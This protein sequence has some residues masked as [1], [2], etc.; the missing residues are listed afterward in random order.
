MTDIHEFNS[1]PV[2]YVPDTS[3]IISGELRKFLIEKKIEAGSKIIIHASLLAELEYQAN[4]GRKSGLA[5]LNEIRRLR[6][7]C[8]EYDI[9]FEYAGR[10][11][12]ASEIKL[13]R[14]GEIDALIRDFAW[15]ATGILITSDKIQHLSTEA[16]GGE[17]IYLQ[18]SKSNLEKTLG[19]E[20]YFDSE[21]LSVHLKQGAKTYVKRGKPGYVT[22]EAYSDEISSK[23]DLKEYAD[24]IIQKAQLFE[25]AFIEIDR[26]GSTIVQYA[27]MRI[28]I[29]RPPF[30]DGWEITAV[31]PLVNLTI[32]DYSLSS[33]L[34]DRLIRRAEGILI[35]GSPGEG[36]TTFARAL[37]LFYEG[38]SQV[39]KTIESPRD[40]DLKTEITQYS[41]NFGKRT[42]IHD[43][44]LLSRP[45]YTIFDE[46][47]DTEDFKL[48]TDLRLAG[49]GL[50]G[51]IHSSTAIDA[52]QR[53]IGRLELGVIPS[54]LDTIIYIKAGM[55]SQV[56]EV[57]MTVK[58]PSGLTESDL[59]RPVVEV[60]DFET[61]ELVYELY[62]F[63]EQT[64]VIPL[65]DIANKIE[66]IDFSTLQEITEA[67]EQLTQYPVTLHPKGQ[68]GRRFRIE[69]AIQDIP[70]VIGRGG[71]TI[72]MLEKTFG[73]KL[74]ID[75][76]KSNPNQPNSDHPSLLRSNMLGL[77]KKTIQL[78]FPKK[79]KNKEVQFL[80]ERPNGT[81]KP[82]YMAA[83]GRSG[84][85]KLSSTSEEGQ[86]FR[87][88]V[89]SDGQRIFWK[90]I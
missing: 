67:I 11:P 54:V 20:R 68:H 59:A 23:T 17:S 36:K 63:G 40:L 71:E 58:V 69:C 2:T 12:N 24:E 25:E 90:V 74:D 50:V 84:K 15:R 9:L 62:T 38:H 44:L 16:I 73:V 61:S 76:S 60:R 80:V 79:M 87:E 34:M 83:T 52:I 30:A 1:E 37:A 53:F 13:A 51:V 33:N 49:I 45:D 32:E 14:A 27:N 55:V 48:Y 82:F 57:K 64:V 19:I 85:I 3:V 28:V 72:K 75:R 29:C 47:R 31:R 56:L 86:L 21:T 18:P 7:F 39:I 5:G 43:I 70:A 88:S 89:E 65:E 66:K 26:P 6:R 42:E 8:N 22:F 78:R 10:R 4:K 81:L 41:K 35:A 46:I 77:H